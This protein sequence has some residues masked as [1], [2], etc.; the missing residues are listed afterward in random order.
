MC[1]DFVNVYEISPGFIDM[2]NFRWNLIDEKEFEK[3][4][5]NSYRK[6]EDIVDDVIQNILLFD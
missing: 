4:K 6:L 3:V 2:E 5:S 1:R